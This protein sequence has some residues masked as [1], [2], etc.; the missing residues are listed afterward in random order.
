[1][2]ALFLGQAAQKPIFSLL[3]A[4]LLGAPTWGAPCCVALGSLWPGPSDMRWL[5]CQNFHGAV[6]HHP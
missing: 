2:P 5:N 3:S 6:N 4:N 1:M